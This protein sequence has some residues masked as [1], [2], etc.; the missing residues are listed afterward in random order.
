MKTLWTLVKE[1]Q[2][3]T[4]S[5]WDRKDKGKYNYDL[6]IIKKLNITLTLVP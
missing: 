6:K 3:I 5:F 4:G 2:G 1:Q